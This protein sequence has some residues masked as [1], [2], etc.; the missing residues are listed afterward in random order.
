M[1]DEKVESRKKR[2]IEAAK[3]GK[4]YL[5]KHWAYAAEHDIDFFEAYVN[6]YNK[7]LTDGKAL[8][9]KTRELIVIGIL[10][11]R[12]R[13]SGVY[14]HI[15][16]ALKHGAT[17]QEILEA[18][19]TSMIPGGGPTWLIGMQAFMKVMEEEGKGK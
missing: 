8:P 18:I 4:D 16:R 6:L 17:K 2:V 11:F 13:E 12:G 10:A 19:E 15:K 5:P 7:G 14:D 9:A 3:E 1:K